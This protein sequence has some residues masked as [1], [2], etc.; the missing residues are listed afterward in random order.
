MLMKLMLVLAALFGVVVVSYLIFLYCKSQKE[1]SQEIAELKIEISKHRRNI[2]ELQGQKEE[3]V[4]R[5]DQGDKQVRAFLDAIQLN[6]KREAWC[7]KQWL[8]MPPGTPKKFHA[9]TLKYSSLLMTKKEGVHSFF[10]MCVERNF[11]KAG[12]WELY[13]TLANASASAL[14]YVQSKI[15]DGITNEFVRSLEKQN[16]ALRALR[17]D[18]RPLLQM[19]FC[20]IYEQATPALKES[21]VGADLLLI[22]AGNQ[23]V[24]NGGARMFWLQAKRQLGDP[25]ILDCSYANKNG[26]QLDALKKVDVPEKGSFGMYM[27]Y[28]KDIPFIPALALCQHMP[29]SDYKNVDLSL[30]GARLAE[31]ITLF[32][33]VTEKSIG[34]FEDAS[35]TIRFLDAVG[36]NKPL[37][38]V[39]VCDESDRK[40][41][42][43]DLISKIQNHYQRKRSLN[44]EIENEKEKGPELDF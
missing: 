12:W 38:V 30:Y 28:A 13:W 43:R 37:Y 22:I 15:E 36:D 9:T 40:W 4:H 18:G 39:A 21:D 16:Q 24:S 19:G 41:S 42:K 27:Q 23:L 25:Y 5:C 31:I 17:N 20:K 35:S 6:A 14:E 33:A 1:A 7:E 3:L 44:N 11:Q 29:L 8:E 2:V 34:S 10:D 32:S 26:P